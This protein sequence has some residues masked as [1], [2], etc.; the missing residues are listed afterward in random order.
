MDD[1]FDITQL[2]K[3]RKLTRV[4]A[5]HLTRELRAHLSTLAPLLN[6]KNVFGEHIRGGPKV[7]GQTATQAFDDLQSLYQ[8]V[9][10]TKPFNLRSRFD[11]PLSLLSASPDIQPTTYQYTA[12]DEDSGSTKTITIT[13]P[14]KWTLSF[15]GFGVSRLSELLSTAGDTVGP[16][17]QECVLH[18]LLLYVTLEKRSGLRNLLQA[19]RF[20][21]ATERLPEFGELPLVMISAPLP[22]MRPPDR[23]IIESTEISGTTQ[24]EEV[25]DSGA[26]ADLEDPIKKKLAELAGT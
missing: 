19:L 10:H 6:P 25:V 17:L 20:S 5:D 21:V 15:E 2:L 12:N 13:S 3:L 1:G 11:T 26:I 9:H 16:K 4:I 8:A 14:L 7:A 24:F 23:V 18:N 22:T